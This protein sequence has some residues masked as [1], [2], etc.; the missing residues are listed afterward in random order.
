LHDH[1]FQGGLAHG[2]RLAAQIVPVKL[3][4]VEGPHERVGIIAPVTDTIK[5]GDAVRP[6]RDGLPVDNAG[7]RAQR[8]QGLHYERKAPS[9]VITRSAIQPHSLAV[10]PSDNPEAVVLDLV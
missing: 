5:V 6:A 1:P 7:A 9:Q 4:Q 8:G 10:L 2:K 3:D